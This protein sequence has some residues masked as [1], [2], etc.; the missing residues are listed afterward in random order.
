MDTT[1]LKW[2]L[3]GFVFCFFVG[4]MLHFVYEW[5]GMVSV[6]G[7][8][9]AVNESTWEHLKMAF[10]PMLFFLLIEM[11]P[12]KEKIHNFLAA[13][14]I[15]LY[16]TPTLIIALYYGHIATSLPRSLVFDIGSFG[17]AIFVS[18]LVSYKIMTL[19]EWSGLVKK[20]ASVCLVFILA[21][22][23]LFTYFP[24]QMFLFQDPVTDLYGFL[25]K[26]EK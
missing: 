20:L 6:V 13:K 10:W 12:L 14:T 15:G 24:P 25:L 19:R 5:S 1:L 23:L 3:G 4:A 9:A 22:F 26:I 18:Q 17:A 16:L 2:E 7:I 11:R 21:C 8:I